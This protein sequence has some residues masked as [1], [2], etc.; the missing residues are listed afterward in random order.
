MPTEDTGDD[1]RGFGDAEWRHGGPPW[2]DQRWQDEHWHGGWRARRRPPRWL[3]VLISA[4]VQVI[5]IAVAVH[6]ARPVAIVAALVAFGASGLLLVSSRAPGP[7]VA[8][9]AALCT[10]GI[11]LIGGP[12]LA[13]APL[14]FAV[15]IAIH[16]GERVW[17]WSSLGG[18]ALIGGIGGYLLVDSRFASMRVLIVV[19]VLCLVVALAEGARA[20]RSRYREA[21]RAVAARR[22]SAAEAERMRIA[23]ELHDVLAHSLSQI[24]VQA[25]VG[26]H[27]FD[28]EPEKARE[29]LASIKQASGRALDEVRGV[30]GVLRADGEQPARAPEPDLAAIPDLI[31]T[32]REAGVEVTVSDELTSE[33]PSSVQFVI[34]RVLQE[35]LT[36]VVKHSTARVATVRLSDSVNVWRVEVSDPGPKTGAASDRPGRGLTGMRE[37]VQ[38]LGGHVAAE[39]AGTG[40]TVMAELPRVVAS[41]A[42]ASNEQAPS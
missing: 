25:G 2:Q 20:R 24:S 34:Y 35:A 8:V 4:V 23:R 32:T 26:L 7:A 14:V 19:I 29:A 33:V 31:R 6:S 3:P 9:I 5:S 16:A 11:A 21:S 22:Q 42:P 28:A 38:L 30:L 41:P 27:L 12:P 39:S 36:N 37:R 15:V 40:F 17:V 10:P 1:T 13:A 18:I